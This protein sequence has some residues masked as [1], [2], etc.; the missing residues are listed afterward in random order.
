[1]LLV[2]L[3]PLARAFSLADG[4][5]PLVVLLVDI[6]VQRP[7]V[8]QSVGI[9][10]HDLLQDHKDGHIPQRSP[11]GGQH[12]DVLAIFCSV[13]HL[14]DCPAGQ[15]VD[16]RQIEQH[17]LDSSP[18]PGQI[19]WLILAGLY[20]VLAQESRSIRDVHQGEDAGVEPVHCEDDHGAAHHPEAPRILAH[21]VQ[22]PA[23]SILQEFPGLRP[24]S[25]QGVHCGRGL[26]EN[27][28]R[29]TSA[30]L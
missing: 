20:L 21:G 7:V 13:Y 3:A 29:I 12:P 10:E 11:E 25:Q 5:R 28:S 1:M 14:V 30:A 4:C 9:V 23:P 22:Q 17:H 18:E 26:G 27:Y 6:L 15:K 8:Q 2:P 19:H 16:H 24:A